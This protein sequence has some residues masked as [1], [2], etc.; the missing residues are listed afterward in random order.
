M[1][2]GQ[3]KCRPPLSKYRS[4]NSNMH[5]PLNTKEMT[6]TVLAV[7]ELLDYWKISV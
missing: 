1:V 7:F 3:Y 6:I 5:V 4:V 2:T